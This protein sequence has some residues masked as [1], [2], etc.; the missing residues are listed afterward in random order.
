MKID[1]N[2][3][4]DVALRIYVDFSQFIYYNEKK[5][6]KQVIKRKK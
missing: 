4:S 6:I 5:I 3:Y 1:G 2:M